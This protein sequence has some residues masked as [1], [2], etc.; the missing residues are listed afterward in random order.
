M[1]NHWGA[2][3]HLPCFRLKKNN[4]LAHGRPDIFSSEGFCQLTNDHWKRKY[5]L[6]VNLQYS[7]VLGILDVIRIIGYQ[8]TIFLTTMPALSCVGNFFDLAVSLRLASLQRRFKF[9]I[10]KF[11]P[12]PR[13]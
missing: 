6:S 11:E 2:L 1:L 9:G 10:S 5:F 4:M 7:A 3:A 8:V 12:R 13:R